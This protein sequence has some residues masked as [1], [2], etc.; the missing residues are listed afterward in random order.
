MVDAELGE[1]RPWRRPGADITDY[2][3]Y[4]FNEETWKFY[5]EKQR[6]LRAEY[7]MQGKIRCA[8]M[9]PLV[10]RSIAFDIIPCMHSRLQL[11]VV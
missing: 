11:G 9:C 7:Q 8:P 6:Q 5:I 4:G 2:F 1:E 3:N 10:S